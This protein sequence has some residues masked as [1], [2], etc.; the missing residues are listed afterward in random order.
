[1]GFMA[2]LLR[3]ALRSTRKVR[4]DGNT[5][6]T[7]IP[8]GPERLPIRPEQVEAGTGEGNANS[9]LLHFGLGAH[10]GAVTV[11]IRWPNGAVRT[12]ESPQVDRVVEAALAR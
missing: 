6:R 12:V 3:P 11:E 5:R 4:Q 10:A 8:I 2:L 7:V 1:M 9:P